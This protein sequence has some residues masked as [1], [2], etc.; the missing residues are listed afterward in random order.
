MLSFVYSKTNLSPDGIPRAVKAAQ[1]SDVAVVCVG[2]TSHS[3]GG[4]G[5]GGE[6]GAASCGEGFDRADLRLPG[7]QENLVRAVRDTGTPTVVV[8]VNGRPYSIP[9]IAKKVPAIVEAWY[10]GIEGG[11]ALADVLFGKVNPSGKLPVTFPRSV[12]HVPSFYNHKPS[13]RGVYHKPGTPDKPGRDYVFSDPA[14][15]FPFG[16]GL[17][18]TTFKCTNLRLSPQTILP[19]GEVTVSVDVQNT[20]KVPGKEVVQ[21][22]VNDLVSS[23]TTPVRTLRGFRK[24]NLAPGKKE[25]VSFTLNHEDLALFDENYHWTV[26][27]GDFEIMVGDLKKRLTVKPSPSR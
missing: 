7:A 22:Y 24:V 8:L 25:T 2:G 17:S 11:H 13:A 18:Y 10:P 19:A 14:P 23:V 4:I 3:L 6:D 9:W 21:L 16:H 20:G 12:G 5:W 26:E 1:E 27:P 15:L